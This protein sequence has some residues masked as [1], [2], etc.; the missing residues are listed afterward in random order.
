M[1]KIH[2]YYHK[3]GEVWR[4]LETEDINFV[5]SEIAQMRGEAKAELNKCGFDHIIYGTKEY[6]EDG[7]KE[8]NFYD[9]H[10]S[11]Y[12]CDDKRLDDLA[13]IYSYADVLL[14]AVHKQG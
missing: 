1:R 2:L 11:K 6:D 9:P 13:D 14:L 3:N 10:D 5:N 8:V 7:L 4:T 12:Q